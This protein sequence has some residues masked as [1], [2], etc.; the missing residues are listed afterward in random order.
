M[1]EKQKLIMDIAQECFNRKGLQYTSIDEIVKACKMSKAT[2]Y[3]YFSTKEDLANEI[4]SYSSK[5]LLCRAKAIDN[6][7]EIHAKEKLKKKIILI[8]EYIL[9]D[10]NLNIEIIEKFSEDKYQSI[11]KLKKIRKNIILDEYHKSLIAVYGD[12]I[13]S[14]VW[15]IVLLIDSLVHEFVLITSIKNEKFKPDFVG[16]YIIRMIDI[17]IEALKGVQPMIE[18]SI[19]YYIEDNVEDN[20]YSSEDALFFETIKKLKEL[21]KTDAALIRQN[22]L[23]EAVNK[24][25][26]EAKAGLYDSLMMDALLSFL[27]KEKALKA[28][29]S[30]L[31]KL[32]N[33]LGVM[34]NE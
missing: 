28:E 7:L 30:I 33:K 32:K 8:W 21:I 4:L 16:D 2:F 25:E 34:L 12:E 22:K 5:K 23:I 9:Y 24:L 20:L 6:N 13:E 27:E 26:E 14:T 31:N 15:E 1:G 3:K 18:K 19:I 29:V 17:T 11:N 10:S